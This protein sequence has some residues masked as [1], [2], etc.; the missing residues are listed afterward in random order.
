[1]NLSMYTLQPRAFT[2]GHRHI[3]TGSEYTGPLT[4]QIFGVQNNHKLLILIMAKGEDV[5]RQA[6]T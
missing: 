3:D 6:G 2:T 5:G 4:P 1:M